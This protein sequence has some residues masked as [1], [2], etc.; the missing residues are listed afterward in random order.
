MTGKRLERMKWREEM[1][2]ENERKN[3]ILKQKRAKET[4]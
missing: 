2:G 3:K 1:K 4:K